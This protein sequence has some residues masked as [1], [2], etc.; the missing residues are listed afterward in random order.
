VH[1]AT[2]ADI[3]GQ[4]YAFAAKNPPAPALLIYQLTP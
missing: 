2:L 3:G 4:R 1:T